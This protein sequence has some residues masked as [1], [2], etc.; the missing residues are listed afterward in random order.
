LRH[1]KR[2]TRAAGNEQTLTRFYS[3]FAA[4]DADTMASCY[5][6]DAIIDDPAFSLKGRREVG[7]M[8]HMLCDATKSKGRADW[9]LEFRDIH[10]DDTMGRAHREA[11]YRFSVTKRVV[12]N[13]IEAEFTFNPERMIATHKD[14]FDFSRRS[15]QALGLGGIVLG[16]IPFFRRQS[17][18]HLAI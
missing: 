11:H 17:S 5:A 13:I 3:T 4:L 6:E 16:W 18:R 8:W 14:T 2:L 15:R 12:D 7:G 1:R 10:A 9:R